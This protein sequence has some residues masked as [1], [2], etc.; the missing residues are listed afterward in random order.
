MSE[1][2]RERERE[3]EGILTWL[4]QGLSGTLSHTITHNRCFSQVESEGS[5][6]RIIHIRENLKYHAN[7]LE[8]IQSHIN[9]K[10]TQLSERVS[11]IVNPIN[12]TLKLMNGTDD[13]AEYDYTMWQGIMEMSIASYRIANL[14]IKQIS[15]VT[16]QAVYLVSEN[17]INNILDLKSVV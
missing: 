12:I 9:L 2:A 6:A 7:K 11:E 10:S 8:T 16:N 5:E 1:S 15:D 14:D 17:S 13:P 4:T 3:R